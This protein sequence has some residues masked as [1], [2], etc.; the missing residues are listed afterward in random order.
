MCCM[1]KPTFYQR[2]Y[3][4]ILQGRTQNLTWVGSFQETVELLIEKKHAI[5]RGVRGHA[6]PGKF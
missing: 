4:R 1:Y 6:P 3:V 5:A 2:T